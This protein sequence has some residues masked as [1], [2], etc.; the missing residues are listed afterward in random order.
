MM[1]NPGYVY[2]VK[3]GKYYK[4]GKTLEPFKRIRA[5]QTTNPEDIEIIF[6]NR[7]YDYDTV[8]KGLH[9]N[10]KSKHHRGEWYALDESDYELIT[11]ILGGHSWD[12]DF[13]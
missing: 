3:C 4:I 9:W 11:K 2:V 13:N 8:E 6:V 10:M 5:L 1:G 7:V 12:R